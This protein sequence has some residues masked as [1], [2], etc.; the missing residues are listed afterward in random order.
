[1]K[2]RRVKII[3]IIAGL[4]LLVYYSVYFKNLDEYKAS[5]TAKVFDASAYAAGFWQEK[6]IPNLD[7]A[8]N[9]S[10]LLDLLAVD[11]GKAFSEHSHALGIGNLRYFLVKGS[12]LID[13]VLEDRVRINLRHAS[14]TSG[15]FL[16]TEFIF[17]NAVRDA[18]GLININEFTNT[19]DFNAVSDGLNRIIREQVVAPVK[20]NLMAGKAI[21][22]TG[23]L[24]LNQEHYDSS[25]LEVI[26]VQINILNKGATD[27]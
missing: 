18:T 20:P 12:G 5:H 23:A 21:S 1:M 6:L 17:G 24:E 15:I 4:G 10:T 27:Q 14:A 2:T 25:A 8:I 13:S 16:A 26:P 19:M 22:F 3:L 7:K 11:P 9:L